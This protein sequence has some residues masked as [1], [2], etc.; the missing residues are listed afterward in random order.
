ML[1]PSIS[2]FLKNGYVDKYDYADSDTITIALSKDGEIYLYVLDSKKKAFVNYTTNEAVY[3]LDTRTGYVIDTGINLDYYGPSAN[4]EIDNS[5]W[6]N[7]KVNLKLSENTTNEIV[8]AI[9]KKDGKEIAK[10]ESKDGKKL[11]DTQVEAKANGEYTYEIKDKKGRTYQGVVKVG[12]ID[13][14]KPITPEITT[15]E[16]KLKVN[17]KDDKEAT[18]DYAKSGIKARYIS[19]DKK[20][21]KLVE[22]NET[23]VKVNENQILYAKTI[24]NAGNESNIAERAYKAEIGNV[25]VIYQDLNG[26]KLSDDVTL[27]GEVGTAYKAK[28]KGF[29]KYELVEVVGNEEGK[30]QKANQFVI[31]KYKKIEDVIENG[32]V[33][34][35]Y[36]DENGN[37]IKDDITLEGKVGQDYKTEKAEFEVYEFVKVEGKEEGKFEKEEQVVIYKY[38]KKSGRVII[39][40]NDPDGIKIKENDIIVGKI[41]TDYK[42]DRKV[43]DGYELVEVIGNE[44]EKFKL[45][46][47]FVIYKYKKIEKFDMPQTGQ[48]RIVYIAIGIIIVL[49]IGGLIYI[50][51]NDL[52]SKNTNKSK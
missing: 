27:S 47:Q 13:K 18:K 25:V 16:G 11:K 26:N 33:I 46:D 49:S 23:L 3:P 20:D 15:Y 9:M 4:Y 37:S 21:W 39:I 8:E 31:Y 28:R 35:K 7:Q 51:W 6:T 14:L 12:N 43:I 40:F 30:F 50:K 48:T 29:E 45:A 17:F 34:V 24:D 32:K 22:E 19:F 2:R 10:Y 36:Q 44:Q 1:S 5:K 42:I 41:D 52:K 38:N